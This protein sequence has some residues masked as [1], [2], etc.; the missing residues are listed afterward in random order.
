MF[1]EE[2]INRVFLLQEKVNLMTIL[3]WKGPSTI[4]VPIGF[5]TVFP[6]FLK[7]TLFHPFK[8]FLTIFTVTPPPFSNTH[9]KPNSILCPCGGGLWAT[10]SGLSSFLNNA[11]FLSGSINL[12]NSGDWKQLPKAR[13]H[14]RS[15]RKTCSTTGSSSWLC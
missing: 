13:V 9:T 5:N 7:Y 15:P 2:N 10:R 11:L 14:T 8:I 3:S 6:E 4:D 1:L 12:E